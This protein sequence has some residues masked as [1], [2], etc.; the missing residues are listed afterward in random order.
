MRQKEIDD[1][2]KDMVGN[3]SD[4]EAVDV[5]LPLC[6]TCSTTYS[7]RSSRTRRPKSKPARELT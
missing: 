2:L 4:E 3:E 7:M 5:S 1:K 6:R